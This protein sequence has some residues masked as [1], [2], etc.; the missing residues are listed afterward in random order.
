M[1]RT[2]RLALAVLAGLLATVALAS[3]A[4]AQ[5]DLEVRIRGVDLNDEGQTQVVVSVA[6][7]LAEEGL[8][9]DA[10][11]VSEQGEVVGDLGVE[12]LLDADAVDI[13][14]ALAIDASGSMDGQ[15]MED[16]RQAATA[17]VQELAPLGV[18]VSVV[19]FAADVNVLTPFTSDLSELVPAIQGLEASGATLLY[20]AVVVA[21][22]QL[23][24]RDGQRNLV[25]FSDGGDNGSEAGLDEAIAA[26]SDAEAGI[27]SIALETDDLEPEILAQMAAET[28][29]GDTLSVEDS[30]EL[31]AAFE[32]LAQEIASQYVLT[33]EGTADDAELDLGV[34][35][36]AAGVTASDA[37]VVLNPRAGQ[38]D[39]DEPAVGEPPPSAAP[40]SPILGIFANQ[41]G[42]WL[43]IAAAALAIGTLLVMFLAAP[44]E[45]AGARTLKR[46]MQAAEGQKS[47]SAEAGAGARSAMERATTM[48]EQRM[49]SESR[50]DLQ[51]RLE[52][53]AWLLRPSEFRLIQI[54]AVI[55]GVVIG[56]GLFQNLLLG[57]GIG[58]IAGI[59]PM[60]VLARAT[61]R[62]A[63][64]FDE[65][66]PDVLQLLSGSLRA[67][68]GFLQAIDTVSQEATDPAAEEFA[69]VLNE[70][71]LGG[72]VEVAL[73]AMA[74]RLD[75]EDFRWVV[76][77]VNIQRQVGGNLAEL[78]ETVAETIRER[79]RLRRHVKALSAEG[80]LSALILILLPFGVA[81]WIA[82]VNPTYMA[83]LTG[84]FVGLIAIVVMLVLMGIGTAWIRKIIKIE[85]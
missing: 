66:L 8:P 57:L 60:L 56:A 37:V 65:Q 75:S 6:G 46:S 72:S 15:P 55:G 21:S 38:P 13:D 35:V 69:R 82:F 23:A 68:Y 31:Q 24:E 5:E 28:G 2:T 4:V 77:A 83:T 85:I 58:A 27:T 64:K 1:T 29:G 50:A 25:I 74:E 54:A 71:R 61:D 62:R 67:G 48:V 11:A 19:S 39:D 79:E 42:L 59:V 30:E 73:E 78:L 53:A 49:G 9:A 3:L 12:P 84:S 18:E 17:F 81:G 32:S 7:P 20:D 10:F 44:V 70:A 40:P 16:A 33:Y 45:T 26:A 76:I 22:E 41:F 51:Q 43:G 36:T 34:T 47:K 14:V 52:R 63:R 80:R